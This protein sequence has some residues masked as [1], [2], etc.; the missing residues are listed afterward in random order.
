MGPFGSRITADNFVPAGVPVIRGNNLT[1]GFNESSFVYLTEE[2]A[3]ELRSAISFPGDIVFTHRGT[4]GQVGL[5]PDRAKHRCYIVS[6]S[7]MLLS[8]DG[9]KLSPKVIYRFFRSSQGQQAL[10]S[11]T[12]QTGVPAIARPT[13]SLKAIKFVCPPKQI[14]D[15]FEELSG[16]WDLKREINV[17]ENELLAAIRDALLARLISGQ[18]RIPEAEKLAEAAL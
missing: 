12:N 16:R 1:D 17:R 4:L 15:C 8:I 5:I 13:T 9:S 18:L 2:K 7:Q 3:S 14:S 6:Q 10:L 11:N